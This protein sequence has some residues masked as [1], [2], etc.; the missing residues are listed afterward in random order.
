MVS[1]PVVKVKKPKFIFREVRIY[2]S[3]NTFLYTSVLLKCMFKAYQ[4]L[5]TAAVAQA[6]G[7]SVGI[8]SGRLGVRIPAV[9]DLSRENR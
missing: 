1:V 5:L 7:F 8:A 4:D 3:S 2:Q 6:V 9:R